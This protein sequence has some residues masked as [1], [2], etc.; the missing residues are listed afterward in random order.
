M[1]QETQKQAGSAVQLPPAYR[2]ENANARG[3]SSMRF[4]KILIGTA[5]IG[6]PRCCAAVN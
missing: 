6:A 2:G 5:S 1:A 3:D 4:F